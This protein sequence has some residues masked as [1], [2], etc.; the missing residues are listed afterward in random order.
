MCHVRTFAHTR[1]LDIVLEWKNVT[2]TNDMFQ[3]GPSAAGVGHTRRGQRIIMKAM[4]DKVIR[5]WLD[6]KKP[7]KH[8][9]GWRGEST[10][11]R[12]DPWGG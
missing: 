11:A 6:A 7:R 4:T 3:R 9:S 2:K 1:Q 12:A 5:A 8:R 10:G